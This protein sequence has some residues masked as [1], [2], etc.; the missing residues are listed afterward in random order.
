MRANKKLLHLDCGK[1]VRWLAS[2]L[3]Y[4]EEKCLHSCTYSSLFMGSLERENRFVMAAKREIASLLFTGCWW[5]NEMDEWEERRGIIIALLP[6]WCGKRAG[7]SETSIWLL[8]WRIWFEI[9]HRN[10]SF[11]N[12]AINLSSVWLKYLCFTGNYKSM[13]YIF[14][15]VWPR[16]FHLFLW[17]CRCQIR[18]KPKSRKEDEE[19]RM[20][21]QQHRI[22]ELSSR[23]ESFLRA[24][25]NPERFVCC[26][27]AFRTTYMKRA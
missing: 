3:R 14:S 16:L 10:L 22:I 11:C 6:K 17:N 8:R 23:V 21:Q 15:L 18:R 7:S 24:V 9:M 2:F 27:C 4:T 13:L 19:T 1:S 5:L 26:C 20:Q 12:H 25:K